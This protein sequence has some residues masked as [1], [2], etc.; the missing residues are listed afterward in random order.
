M[1]KIIYL[2]RHC[3]ADGQKFDAQLTVEGIEQA[4]VLAEFLSNKQIDT[5]ITSPFS[6]AFQSV[7]PLADMLQLQLVKDERL[8]ERVLSE[9]DHPNWLHMLEESFKRL[10]LTFPGGESSFQAME[11]GS[12]VINEIVRSDSKVSVVAT[13]GNLM[14]LILKNYEPT[15]G[16]KEWQSLT[17]PDVFK[18]TF[19]GTDVAIERIWSMS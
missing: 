12:S 11:R 2:V 10:D 19:L 18:I 17:N 4:K 1:V 7:Q 14:S 15:F 16:F 13:H 8:G 3:K 9:H 6:R 5:I